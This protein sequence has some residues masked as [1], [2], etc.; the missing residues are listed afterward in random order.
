M[1]HWMVLT[2]FKLK[3]TQIIALTSP[4]LTTTATATTATSSRNVHCRRTKQQ[5][6]FLMMMSSSSSSAQNENTRGSPQQVLGGSRSDDPQQNHSS[7]HGDNAQLNQEKKRLLRKTIRSKLSQMSHEEITRQSNLVWDK[8]FQLPQYQSSQS[9]GLF[10]SMPSG[11]IHTHSACERVLSDGKTLYLP[12]V[13]LDF[14]KCD[15]ELVRVAS[16]SSS[17]SQLQEER[18][19]DNRSPLTFYEHWPRNKWGIP[20]PPSVEGDGDNH[21]AKPGDIDLMI[22]PGLGFD[23]SGGRLGQGKGYYDRFLWKMKS[24]DGKKKEQDRPVLVAVGLEPSFVSEGTIPMSHHDF[25]MDMV[26]LPDAVL[27]C[28]CGKE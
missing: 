10:L 6:L 23:R 20:E 27:D 19:S 18:S 24:K 28:Q 22:V 17:S 8:V 21:I 1:F 13:G 12:R 2:C 25:R 16:S 9:V 5:A 11:E 7:N 14:E 26:V 3:K 15:M 4:I